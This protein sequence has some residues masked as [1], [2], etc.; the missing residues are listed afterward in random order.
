M[1]DIWADASFASY[2]AAADAAYRALQATP[3]I[4][5]GGERLGVISTFFR[6]PHHWTDQ[7]LRFSDLHARLA[8][9]LIERQR[10]EEALRDSEARYR[11][12]LRNLPAAVYTCDAT[13]RVTLFNDAAVALWGRTPD[14]ERDEWC[15]SYKMYHPDGRPLPLDMCPM[16]ISLKEGRALSGEA[17]VERPDG[18]R[19]QVRAYP[20]PIRDTSGSLAGAVNMV[21]DIT[22]YKNT[23]EALR[24]SE[25]RFR[26]YF[27][28]GLIGMATTSPDK[29]VLEVNDELCRI[30]GYERA[31]LLQKTWAELTHPDDLAADV[32]QFQSCHGRRV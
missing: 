19:R 13:G 7:E 6:E 28:L 29:G 15:G 3:L 10:A 12:V 2:P 32:A 17:I 26:R 1:E 9:E 22:D 24:E 18:T 31:E 11:S 23:Q 30:L 20:Q 27:E 25:D 5:R 16:A 4:G 21:L 14:L 8:V